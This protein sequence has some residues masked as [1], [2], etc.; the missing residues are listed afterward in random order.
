MSED[1]KAQLDE[2]LQAVQAEHA[3]VS[4]S[5]E[6]LLKQRSQLD[7]QV[8]AHNQRLVQ[9]QGSYE[10]LAKLQEEK[11]VPQ[12]GPETPKEEKKKK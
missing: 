12:E 5:R 9:L 2:Q 4:E 10:T 7:Q 1:V 6:A 8:A 3:Q 11:P